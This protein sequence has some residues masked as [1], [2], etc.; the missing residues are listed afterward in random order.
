MERS[1][2]QD[3]V[4]AQP[5]LSAMDAIRACAC[6]AEGEHAGETPGETPGVTPAPLPPPDA[7]AQAATRLAF[8]DHSRLWRDFQTVYPV[9]SRRSVGLSIGIN[10]FKRKVCNFACIY[11]QVGNAQPISNAD[12]Y[13][14]RQV[15]DELDQML[16]LVS[17]G[18]IW[19][20]PKFAQVMPEYR[21]VNDIAFAG[22]G[23]PTAHR[24]FD[25]AVQ[26]AA[27]LKQRHGLQDLKIV[28]MT[29]ASLL[30]LPH[31]QHGLEL[32]DQH[33]GE[34]WAKLDAGSTGAFNQV[35]R[36]GV[37][38]QR[39]LDNIHDCAM[40][41]P[42]VIQTMLMRIAGQP[43]T[44]NRLVAYLHRLEDMLKD[45]CKIDRIQLYTIAR[46]PAESTVQPLENRALQLCAKAIKQ[47]LPQLKVQ[48]FYGVE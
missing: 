3:P 21:R 4:D 39:V 32:M 15:R 6:S 7:A 31:V 33:R 38:F 5:L 2:T 18:E 29:N 26:L 1:P 35:N 25:R 37:P 36:S 30:H 34:V 42:T 40:R 13:D 10:L 43:P 44:R 17:S 41:R 48:V 23:E 9:L 11:C 28:L 14:L 19:R 46:P 22:E 20:D 45:G 24:H 8:A 12:V 27:A 47:R 16:G